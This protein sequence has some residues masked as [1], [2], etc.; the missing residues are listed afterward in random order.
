[1]C[2]LSLLQLLTQSLS[3]FLKYDLP[4]FAR[5]NPQVEMT[6]SPSLRKLPVIVGTHINGREKAICVRSLEKEQIMKKAEL[7]RDASGDKLK[8][9][10]KPVKSINESVRGIW[11]PFHGSKWSV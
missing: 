9:V 6:V 11:D 8:K 10:T 2:A 5:A 4:A 1:M 7:L 3:S